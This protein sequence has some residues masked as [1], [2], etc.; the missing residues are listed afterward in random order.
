L[1]QLG[2]GSGLRRETGC[3]KSPHSETSI[4]LPSVKPFAFNALPLKPN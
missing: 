4:P 1:V 2:T 3:L